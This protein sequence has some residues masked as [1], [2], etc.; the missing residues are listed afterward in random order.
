[1]PPRRAAA[2]AAP[3]IARGAGDERRYDD[4]RDDDAEPAARIPVDDA[5]QRRQADELARS[6]RVDLERGAEEHRR[7]ECVLRRAERVDAAALEPDDLV[8]SQA[9]A[10]CRLLDRQ[11]A[12]RSC[13]RRAASRMGTPRAAREARARVAVSF[14]SSRAAL[15]S[16][17]A[18]SRHAWRGRIAGRAAGQGFVSVTRRSTIGFSGFSVRGFVGCR[19]IFRTTFIPVVTCPITA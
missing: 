5:V 13:G 1:M 10:A 11:L 18:E 14:L 9:G 12:A 15:H 2:A 3:E 7:G 6:V 4:Q 16:I 19:E 8:A 17:S